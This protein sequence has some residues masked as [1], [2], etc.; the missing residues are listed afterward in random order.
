MEHHLIRSN[1]P[2]ENRQSDMVQGLMVL[3]WGTIR[4]RHMIL[5]NRPPS[6]PPLDMPMERNLIRSNLPQV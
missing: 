5:I 4:V 2:Q 6:I 3:E 1:L